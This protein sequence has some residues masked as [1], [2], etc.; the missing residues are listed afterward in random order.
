MHLRERAC[1]FLPM[2]HVIQIHPHSKGAFMHCRGGC[3][4]RGAWHLHGRGGCRS[5]HAGTPWHG[6]LWWVPSALMVLHM[7]HLFA[8]LCDCAMGA[9]HCHQ[10]VTLGMHTY[11][12]HNLLHHAAAPGLCICV[13]AGFFHHVAASSSVIRACPEV[14]AIFMAMSCL[15]PLALTAQ[16]CC[17]C[18]RFAA[19][20]CWCMSG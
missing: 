19:V 15:P 4:A 8:C 10:I 16:T 11:W 3:M 20:R 2:S 12:V 18:Y 5:H 1:M 14:H 9:G 17:S 6:C 7:L 13:S